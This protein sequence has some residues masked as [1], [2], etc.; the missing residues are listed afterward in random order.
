M[1]FGI[2]TDFSSFIHSTVVF[3][4]ITKVDNYEPPTRSLLRSSLHNYILFHTCPIHNI[5]HPYSSRCTNFSFS[6]HR[7]KSWCT[8]KSM[9][10]GY[11]GLRGSSGLSHLQILVGSV[12]GKRKVGAQRRVWMKDIM[13]WTCLEKYGK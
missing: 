4:T 9:D 6:L 5:L 10:E 1:I 8:E 11:Y 13:E 7:K 2:T 3:V 12:E